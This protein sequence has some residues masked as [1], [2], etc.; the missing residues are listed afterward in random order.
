MNILVTGGAGYIGSITTV[1][2]IASGYRPIILDNLANAK[3]AVIDHIER[4]SGTRPTFV[5]GDVR[6]G[7]LVLQLLNDEK[8]DA[9]IHFAGLK[10]VAESVADPLLY[11]DNNVHGTAV[12][13]T[14]MQA[15]NVHTLVFS[16]SATVYGDPERNPLTEDAPTRPASP[17]GRTKLMVEM[18]LADLAL[19]APDFSVTALRY[20]NPVGAHPSGLLG[21]DP[22]GVPNNLMP[23]LAQVA[24]GRRE[25]LTVFGAD[26][27]TVDGTGVRD[28]I[29]VLDLADGHVAA[30]RYAHG[31]SG[32]HFFNLGSGQGHSVFAMLNAFGRAV[33]RSLPFE[34]AARRA[35][36]VAQYW[37]DPARAEAALGWR[38][39][40]SIDDMC[41]DTWRWQSLHPNGY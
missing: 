6:D 5:E 26:Y 3:R 12:L 34:V 33:G 30:L 17:Y 21:E 25:K 15:A 9:V 39:T 22:Q 19:A 32:A 28:Y 7:A 11:Y 38:A 27:P 16:S 2:L 41:A 20:F 8:I 10:S 36:D 4:V 40:R 23:Y 18:M 31:R 1:Q 24:V 35:G 29:H 13:L 14:A 37:A